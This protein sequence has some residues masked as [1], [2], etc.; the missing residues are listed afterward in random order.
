MQGTV[1]G[2]LLCTSTVDGLGKQCY[3][4]PEILY[5]YKGVPIPPLGMVDDV[6]CVS[7]VD[8]TQKM[9]EVINTFI[10]RKKLKLSKD[11]CFQ[12][13]VGKGHNN[14]PQLKVHNS[15]MKE[16]DSEKYLGDTI[17]KNG[18]IQSTIESRKSKGHGI[19][20]EIMA[21]INE[22]PLGKHKIDVAMKLREVM[23]LNGILYNSEAWHGVTKK[24]VKTLEAID[25]AGLRGILKAHSKTPTEFLCLET[26]AI[27]IKWIL[28]QRRINFLKHILEKD[29][30]E[31]V[32]KVYMAQKR[33][34]TIGDFA[35][36]VEKDMVN[37]NI[38]EAQLVG[39]NKVDLKKLLKQSAKDAAFK[40][41]KA[42]Q[43]KHIKVKH[44]VY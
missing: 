9:N 23:L 4:T 10:E 11:K 16:A 13:H 17:D 7:N 30:E 12:I 31:L 34:P 28:A 26:G 15:V 20:S 33:D 5:H 1:W 40:E 19:V 43:E 38:T 41:L 8:K 32:E 39:H 21:I 29:N 36:L 27:P 24:H 14:C 42:T 22:I 37:L 44:I 2:S 3:K 18:T 25:E 35:Q 6:V